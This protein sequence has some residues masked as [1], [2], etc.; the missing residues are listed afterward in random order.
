M[1]VQRWESGSVGPTKK[2]W[3]TPLRMEPGQ[4]ESVLFAVTARAFAE[5]VHVMFFPSGVRDVVS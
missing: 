3:T 4:K 1:A 2:G 5:E